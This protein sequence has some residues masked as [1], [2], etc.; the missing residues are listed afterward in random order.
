MDIHRI[1]KTSKPFQPFHQHR[2]VNYQ[3]G[4]VHRGHASPRC[5]GATNVALYFGSFQPVTCKKCLA[6]HPEDAWPT[7]QRAVTELGK[8]V[9]FDFGFASYGFCKVNGGGWRAVGSGVG[10]PT[11]A[12]GGR[13]NKTYRQMINS[14]IWYINNGHSW[15]GVNT[16]CSLK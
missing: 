8:W 10:I 14:V 2:V 1:S 9:I 13:E 16:H 6:A 11:L 7:P 5:M 15:K 3:T 12:C 4:K